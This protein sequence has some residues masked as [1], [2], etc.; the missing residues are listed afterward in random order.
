MKRVN[1]KLCFSVLAVVGVIVAFIFVNSVLNQD[2]KAKIN[3]DELNV[4]VYVHHVGKDEIDTMNK[5]DVYLY[6]VGA[7]FDDESKFNINDH[8]IKLDVTSG[9][10]ITEKV[11][12]D[13]LNK[14][15]LNRVEDSDGNN[16]RHYLIEYDNS[17]D[18][19]HPKSIQIDG[20]K[21]EIWIQIDY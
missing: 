21:I 9:K 15:F 1:K 13:L 16:Y 3:F 12:N 18:I 4:N 14:I 5:S 7:F 20:H 2:A 10:E 19:Q 17:S 8:K 11:S 6:T